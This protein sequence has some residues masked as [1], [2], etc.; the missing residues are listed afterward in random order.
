LPDERLTSVSQISSS[1]SIFRAAQRRSRKA[2]SYVDH[3]LSDSSGAILFS[4]GFVTAGNGQRA[5][6]IAEFKEA[7]WGPAPPMLP[8]G[9]QI[10]VLAEAANQRQSAKTKGA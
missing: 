1:S 9:A 3:H 8:P 2:G 7:T 4:G 10:A 6:V 5:H